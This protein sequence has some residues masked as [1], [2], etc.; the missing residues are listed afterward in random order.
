MDRWGLKLGAD[1]GT[2]MNKLIHQQSKNH[3]AK[4]S[5]EL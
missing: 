4:K 2:T 3:D 5:N 1:A